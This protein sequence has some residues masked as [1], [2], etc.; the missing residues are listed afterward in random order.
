MVL[1][2]WRVYFSRKASCRHCFNTYL[3]IV[4]GMFFLSPVC[5]SG[6]EITSS[7]DFALVQNFGRN[8]ELLRMEL[9][10]PKSKYKLSYITNASPREVFYQAATLCEKSSHLRFEWTRT[11]GDCPPLKF[12]II[13][14]ANVFKDLQAAMGNLNSV[15]RHF[16]IQESPEVTSIDRTKTPTDV[17]MAILRGNRQLNILLR[18]RYLPDDVFRK[19]TLALYYTARLLRHFPDVEQRIPPEPPFISRKTPADVYL[20]LVKGFSLIRKITTLSGDAVLDLKVN[21]KALS[22]VTSSDVYD[23]ASVIVSELAYLHWQTGGEHIIE[24]Y[25]PPPKIPAQVFQRAGILVPQLK[26]LLEQVRKHPD[27]LRNP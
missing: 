25:Q 23:V 14:T 15:K 3:L 9:G 8:L 27:W 18:K 24:S 11:R 22:H 20:R 4:A 10:A 16:N 7:D 21:K 5:S 17:F 13:Q 6:E 1:S 2:K 12:G 26:M 19:V